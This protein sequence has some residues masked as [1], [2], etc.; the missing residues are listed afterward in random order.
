MRLSSLTNSCVDERLDPWQSTA[1][2]LEVGR[3]WINDSGRAL[4]GRGAHV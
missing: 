1:T 2:C 4:L 3:C